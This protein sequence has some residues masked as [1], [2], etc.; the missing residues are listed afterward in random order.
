MASTLA[1]A[2]L[3]MTGEH[4]Q[5]YAG[6]ST[7]R[8][9]PAAAPAEGMTTFA[10]MLYF[11]PSIATVL[12]NPRIPALAVEYLKTC[13]IMGRML[14]EELTYVYQPWETIY[15]TTSQP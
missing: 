15:E 5:W 2:L 9:S 6:G 13:E 7:H 14:K 8:P 4:V 11:L 1:P 3:D 12:V 10:R